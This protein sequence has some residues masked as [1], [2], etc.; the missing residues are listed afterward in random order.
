[1]AVHRHFLEAFQLSLSEDMWYPLRVV[2]LLEGSF[3]YLEDCKGGSEMDNLLNA[4]RM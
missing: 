4:N 1:M 2:V 3:A